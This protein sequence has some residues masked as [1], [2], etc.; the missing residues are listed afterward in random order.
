MY[1]NEYVITANRL[2]VCNYSGYS[3]I[4]FLYRNH[5]NWPELPDISL[6]VKVN[7]RL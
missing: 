2:W 7:S 4:V 6:S 1:G 3:A 5:Q